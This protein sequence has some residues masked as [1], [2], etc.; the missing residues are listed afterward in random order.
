MS[1]VNGMF[2]EYPFSQDVHVSPEME[3]L[4]HRQHINAVVSN[5]RYDENKNII[6]DCAHEGQTY[7]VKQESFLG[8]TYWLVIALQAMEVS[9]EQV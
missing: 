8:L 3:A 2:H 5:A 4:I 6:G 1:V 9:N 7:T